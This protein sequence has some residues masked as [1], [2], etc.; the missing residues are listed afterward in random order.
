V[1]ALGERCTVVT[2]LYSQDA[3]FTPFADPGAVDL[4]DIEEFLAAP[5]QGCVVY[6]R[7]ANC[8]SPDAFMEGQSHDDPCRAFEDRVPMTPI[9]EWTLPSLP[10]RGEHYTRDPIPVGLYRISSDPD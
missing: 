3:G 5:R 9:S 1:A 7:A 8:F 10:Y 4:L 6:Y 2:R